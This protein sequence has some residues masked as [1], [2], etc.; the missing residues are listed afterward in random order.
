ML[1]R[2]KKLVALRIMT[3][4]AVVILLPLVSGA[5]TSPT[6]S[7]LSPLTQGVRSPVKMALD[8]A[9]NIF[10]ADQRV[11]GIV[12]FNTYG[13]QQMT[14]RTTDTLN[15]LAFAQ[16]G[17]LLV[18]QSSAV[19]RYNA[20]TGQEIGRLAGGQLQLPVGIAV[21]NVTGYIYVADSRANQIVVYTASGDYVKAFAQGITADA[22]GNT[23]SNP[24]G[25][26]S[27]PTG[28]SFEKVSRQLAVADTLSNR[29]QFFDVDGN[30]IKSIG[31]PISTTLG[32]PVGMMQFD[33]PAAIA[34]E[35]SKNQVPAVLERMYV[36]DTYQG[37]IQ[38][39]NPVTLSA[40]LVSGT[41]KNYIGSVGAVNGQLMMPSDA[42]FDAVNNRLLVVNGFGNITIYGIDG[43]SNPVDV[44]PPALTIDPVPAT[45]TVSTLTVGGTVEAGASVVVT[46]GLAAVASPVVYP[47]ATTWKS[48]VAGLV[49]GGNT[50][51]VT[52]HDAAGNATLP[53]SVSV[54]YLLPAPVIKIS[55]SVPGLTNTANLVVTGTVDAGAAV[56][57]TNASTSISGPATVAGS[58]WSYTVA[59]AEGVNSISVS[60]EKPMSSVATAGLSVTL[61]TTAPRLAVSALSNGSYASSQIQNIT[62]SVTDSST[63][64]V[65]V[66]NV[67]A[68]LVNNSFSVPVTLVSGSNQI[69]VVAAD[70]AGNTSQDNRTIFYDVTSPVIN[71]VS[72]MDNSFTNNAYV[73]INGRVD[74]DSTVTVAGVAVVVDS[75]HN[76]SANIELVAG[77]NTIEIVATDLAG[78]S[79]TQKRS[80]ILDTFK[81]VLAIT[82][83]VQDIAINQASAIITGTVDDNNITLTYS[84]N[85]AISTTPVDAGSF[86]FKVTFAAE[87]VYPVVVTATDLAGNST[88]ATRSVIYDATPPVL[89]LDTVKWQA[90][91]LGGKI[92]GTV[93]PGASVSVKEGGTAIGTVTVNGNKWSADLS[94]ISYNQ[95]KISVF[96]VDA[97]GNSTSMMLKANGN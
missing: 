66:N 37:N 97:A 53:Q 13:V 7:I 48:D 38:V 21:D 95:T 64:T 69:T 43:G 6:V 49:T 32:A 68:D 24:L 62:G 59:L 14:I 87:G 88:T 27:M 4:L 51:T 46:T 34:F 33:A 44:T 84:I 25:K 77:L 57:V 63:V 89:T 18:S 81:P 50:I 31:N 45:V 90:Q 73:Q 29:V 71:I 19:V 96:A 61:D 58:T 23:V 74:E 78:N 11:G 82:S 54:T 60:A 94:G 2:A 67:P 85:G 1:D 30:F 3:L 41:S 42:V 83:P 55:T 17:S 56:T 47:S 8:A 12:K 92:R 9:G 26:L 15:G 86:A 5:A 91:A 70:A 72:P 39:V 28:I 75:S 93:E 36:V 79:S 16:D 76:W 40:L 10:V 65:L 80:I 52:A 20:A 22:S 35:Y